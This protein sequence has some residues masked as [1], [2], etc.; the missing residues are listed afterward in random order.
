MK[1]QNKTL[2]RIRVLLGAAPTWIA[3]A[4]IISAAVIEEVAKLLPSGWQ[5]NAA[6]IAGYSAA[7]IASA[8]A[9]VRRVTPVFGIERG[10]L[11]LDDR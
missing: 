3:A 8:T 2:A 9:I 4:G 5:D 7:V 11:P 6:Q 1:P 10:I